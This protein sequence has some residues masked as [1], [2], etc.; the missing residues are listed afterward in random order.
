MRPFC[1][2][3]CRHISIY[4]MCDICVRVLYIH[5]WNKIWFAI[6]YETRR[7]ALEQRTFPCARALASPNSSSGWTLT[8]ALPRW[9]PPHILCAHA[10]AAG[11]KRLFRPAVM[12]DGTPRHI[13]S[14]NAS[15]KKAVN[16]YNI[17]P[18]IIA[19]F[20]C[21]NKSFLN[22]YNI[23]K[24]GEYSVYMSFYNFE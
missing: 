24:C 13:H 23:K 3:C 14:L 9:A 10:G 6:S 12:W 20:F 7:V 16:I 2:K 8:N 5:I 18:N 1:K 15:G 21:Q 11:E 17:S 4:Y 22:I 19:Y